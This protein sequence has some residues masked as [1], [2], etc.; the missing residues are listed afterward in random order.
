MKTIFKLLCLVCC[1]SLIAVNTCCAESDEIELLQ[2]QVYD[3]GGTPAPPVKI[4]KPTPPPR[5]APQPETEHFV[6]A[7]PPPPAY[8]PPPPVYRPTPPPQYGDD[9]HFIQ[10]DDFFIQ[11]HGLESRTWIWVELAKMATS[12][13]GSTKGEAEFMKIKNGKNYWTGHYWRTRIASQGELHLGMVVIAFNDHQ[14]HG[15]YQKP[16]RKDRARG[17]SW[18]MARITDMSDMYKGY[19]TVSGN[20]KVGLGNLRIVLR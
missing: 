17:G 20:Y 8:T 6:P 16:E 15:V 9:A 11:R 12:P 4:K 18:F 13:N 14:N 1:T 2:P 3:L 10:P 19:V 7:P 5:P